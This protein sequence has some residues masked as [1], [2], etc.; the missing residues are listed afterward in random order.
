MHILGI[1]IGGTGIKGAIVDTHDGTLLTERRRLE[2]PQPAKPEQIAET[3]RQLVRQFE[4]E[5][6][7]GCCF[8]AVVIGG[9][10]RT[11][12]NIH[13][14][15]LGTR[16]DTLFQE[17]TGLRFEICNDADAAAIAEMRL[18]AGVGLKGLTI[19]VTI[20]T[21]LG[22]GVFL[23]DRLVPNIE[24]GHMFGRNAEPIEQYAGNR[25]RKVNDLSWTEWGRRFNFFLSRTVRVMSPD[26]FILAGGASKKVHKFEDE[27]TVATPIHVARF[28]NNA[29][30]IGAAVAAAHDSVAA[31]TR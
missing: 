10:V 24:L 14:S 12:G 13:R 16:A 11:A 2:T 3:V 20:G 15:W 5:G 9:E 4:Y 31:M 22:S 30:I 23:D 26:H 18:G 25:A 19:T 29:G 7:V 8:P 27:I 6:T 21:G 17:A 28:R 1:D